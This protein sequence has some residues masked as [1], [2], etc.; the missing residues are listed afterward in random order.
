MGETTR[1]ALDVAKGLVRDLEAEGRYGMAHAITC[2]ERVLP[3]I[4]S[5]SLGEVAAIAIGWSECAEW[6]LRRLQ[7]KG[8]VSKRFIFD[9]LAGAEGLRALAAELSRVAADLTPQRVL[10]DV[11]TGTWKKG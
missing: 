7:H 3:L 4:E 9:T 6:A 10:I 1:T 2:F 5:L 11:T 8:A